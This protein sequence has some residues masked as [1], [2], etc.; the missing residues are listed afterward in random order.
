ESHRSERGRTMI[1]LDSGF[2]RSTAVSSPEG[3]GGG[4]NTEQVDPT[5]VPQ[6]TSSTDQWGLAP[7]TNR[8][9]APAHGTTN[10]G[11]DAGFVGAANAGA[12]AAL[13]GTRP[14]LQDSVFLVARQSDRI[15]QDPI[16]VIRNSESQN[17]RDVLATLH[18][19]SIE[20]GTGEKRSAVTGAIKRM[21]NTLVTLAENVLAGAD[22]VACRN[23]LR[24]D[25]KLIKDLTGVRG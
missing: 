18:E 6:T 16:D 3:L 22:T 13:S 5:P 23:S 10:R 12:D 14:T 8:M 2:G 20:I 7:A 11:S 1:N 19:I 24:D 25:F 21:A 4:S 17:D 9:G 15:A